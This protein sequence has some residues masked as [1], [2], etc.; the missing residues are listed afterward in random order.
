[1]SQPDPD[2]AV[3]HCPHGIYVMGE[4]PPVADT[5]AL[6]RAWDYAG[7]RHLSLAVAREL[8]AVVA[9]CK[10]SG[11]AEVWLREMKAGEGDD[12]S[13]SSADPFAGPP[14]SLFGP[15]TQNPTA[16]RR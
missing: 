16:L 14:G 11:D 2:Y 10:C 9:V 6:L 3:F 4:A 13:P 8:G 12:E 5:S 15:E 7:Y 1:M